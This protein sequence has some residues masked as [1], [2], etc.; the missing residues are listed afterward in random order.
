M[1]TTQ[2]YFGLSREALQEVVNTEGYTKEECMLLDEGLRVHFCCDESQVAEVA[3]YDREK[4]YC[5]YTTLEM[6]D[7]RIAVICI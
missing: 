5:V 2:E 4:G 3:Q 1:K 7:S 6:T